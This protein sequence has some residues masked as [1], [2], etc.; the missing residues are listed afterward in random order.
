MTCQGKTVGTARPVHPAKYDPKTHPRRSIRWVGHDHAQD[1]VYLVTVCVQGHVCLFGDIVDGKMRS[2][3]LGRIVQATWYDLPNHYP[4]VELDAFVVM[5]NHVHMIV[6]LTLPVGAGFKPVLMDPK[7]AE[8]APTK[9]HG[10]PKCEEGV[11]QSVSP[12]KSNHCH[13]SRAAGK[14]GANGGQGTVRA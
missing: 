10:L 5:P 6:V 11:W 4:H 2:N 8:S 13:L 1:G 3:E 12:I 9:R 7:P 14:R